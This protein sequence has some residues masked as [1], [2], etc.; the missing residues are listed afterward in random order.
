MI[1]Y[2]SLGF[3]C[4]CPL[5]YS[6]AL[7]PEG[8]C[9]S[10]ESFIPTTAQYFF[11]ACLLCSTVTGSKLGSF[12]TTAP[13]QY[14]VYVRKILCYDTTTQSV[15]NIHPNDYS[16]DRLLH[17]DKKFTAEVFLATSLLWVNT[18]SRLEQTI[19]KWCTWEEKQASGKLLLEKNIS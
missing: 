15:V 6:V 11:T 7:Y 8:G 4:L 5:F 16:V 13:L 19:A 2:P 17:K 10:S 1:Y 9:I 14:N 12:K 18:F 3:N